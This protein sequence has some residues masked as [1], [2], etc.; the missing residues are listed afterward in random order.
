VIIRLSDLAIAMLKFSGVTVIIPFLSPCV[1]GKN[2]P[3]GWQN[4][5]ALIL[6]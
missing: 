5:P 1:G 4:A 2:P 6:R 3:A